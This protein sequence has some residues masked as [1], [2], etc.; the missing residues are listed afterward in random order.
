MA[1]HV[2]EMPDTD[3][4]KIGPWVS[5]LQKLVSPDSSTILVGHSIGCQA[6]LRYLEQAADGLNIEHVVLIA[7]W[8]RLDE[9]TIKEEGQES[10]EIAKPWV[11]TPINF[12]EVTKRV[13]K[14]LR[15]FFG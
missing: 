2:P 1:V 10:E 11:E 15:Y 6:I 8:M 4:P 14:I 12:S 5:T 7:P 9:E 3:H 13:N